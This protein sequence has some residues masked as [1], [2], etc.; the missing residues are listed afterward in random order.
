MSSG[1]TKRCSHFSTPVEADELEF[2]QAIETFKRE[3]NE[4]FPSWSQVLQ[5]LKELG[6]KRAD[7]SQQQK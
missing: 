1:R 4:P 5:L 7:R 3:Q 6:Y 2:I